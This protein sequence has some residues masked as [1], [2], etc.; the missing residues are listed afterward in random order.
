MDLILMGLR[1][2]GKTTLG[3]RLAREHGLRFIDL[4]Q[5]TPKILGLATVA[6]AWT[7]HGEPAF[8]S[9]EVEALKQTIAEDPDILAL[10]GGTPTAPGA[11]QIVR[12]LKAAPGAVPRLIY[13]RASPPV[14]AARLRRSGTV[15][16]PSLTGRGVIEEIEEVFAARDPAYRAL[17]DRVVEMDRID[18]A[19]ALQALSSILEPD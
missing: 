8:R 16:R 13:L 1:G 4:D 18:E 15:G 5:R 9:A 17:A 7:K 10:G 2:S 3:E 11:D 19:A 6:E 14:L 12:S